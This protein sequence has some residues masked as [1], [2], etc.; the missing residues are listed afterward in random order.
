MIVS[1]HMRIYVRC[2]MAVKKNVAL[3]HN[4]FKASV[5]DEIKLSDMGTSYR[6]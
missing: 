2:S 3:Q 4:A 5:R 1:P 6:K